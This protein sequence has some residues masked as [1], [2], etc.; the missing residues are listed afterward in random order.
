MIL[1]PNSGIMW[2]VAT[3]GITHS[4]KFYM[5]KVHLALWLPTSVLW[6]V[7]QFKMLQLPAAHHEPSNRAYYLYTIL[8]FTSELGLIVFTRLTLKFMALYH[9][10]LSLCNLLAG[11]IRVREKHKTAL[12]YLGKTVEGTFTF[13]C[14]ALCSLFLPVDLHLV[15]LS[16]SLTLD[17]TGFI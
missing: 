17:A 6:V 9:C 3:H 14:L 2:I 11:Q 5:Q 1:G 4:K 7:I 12:N 10:T 16:S 15:I 8:H 13:I